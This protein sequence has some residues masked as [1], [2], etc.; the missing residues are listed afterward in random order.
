MNRRSDWRWVVPGA[1]AAIAVYLCYL[2]AKP[3]LP[4]I[5]GASVLAVLLAPLHTRL[6]KS[7]RR[8]N[9][10]ALLATLLG[11]IVVVAPAVLLGWAAVDELRQ[12]YTELNEQKMADGSWIAYLDR[13]STPVLERVSRWSGVEQEMIRKAV[14]ERLQLTSAAML[15]AATGTL[16]EL[17]SSL[18]QIVIGFVTLFFFLRDGGGIL[19]KASR[20]MPFSHD[21]WDSLLQQISGTIVA[22]LYGVLAVGAAQGFLTGLGMWVA[23]VPSPVLWGLITMAA[24]AIPVVGSGLV[25][26]PAGL[27]LIASGHWVRGVLLWVWGA[28]AVSMLDNIVRPMVVSGRAHLNPLLVFFSLLGGVTVFGFIG[29]FLGPVILSLAAALL[30][31]LAEG[32]FGKRRAEVIVEGGLTRTDGTVGDS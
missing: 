30:S 19:E 6:R 4:A 3:Y 8:K 27:V 16:G 22:N 20:L 12:I 1:M 18:V 14:V 5:V 7:L 11:V 2:L 17:T 21:Q 23:G 9:L 25:W 31:M 13:I 28:A 24:S 15:R 26:G 29:V 10:A 32:D